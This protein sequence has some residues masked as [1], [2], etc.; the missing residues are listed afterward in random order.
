M[1]PD[2]IDELFRKYYNDAILYTIT[3]CRNKE[4][5]EDIVSTAFYKA[6]A[7]EDN[8]QNFKA[9]LLTVCRNEFLSM[10]RKNSKLSDEEISEEIADE[11]ESAAD[12]IIRQEEYKALYRAISLLKNEQREAITLFYFSG[13]QIKDIAGVL[14]VSEANVKVLLYRGRDSLKKILEGTL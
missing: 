10:C 11:T 13:L 8:V 1:K 14:G 4:R 3:L 9:W 2:V 6:L 5:A 12:A 7:T